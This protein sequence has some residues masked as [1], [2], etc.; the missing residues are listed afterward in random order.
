VSGGGREG[1]RCSL[2]AG[3]GARLRKA[4]EDARIRHIWPTR[5]KRTRLCPSLPGFPSF[6]RATQSHLGLLDRPCPSS[7]HLLHARTHSPSSMMG[8]H[9]GGGYRW[10]GPCQR[11]VLSRPAASTFPPW[12]PW[13]RFVAPQPPG[14]VRKRSM[15]S[16]TARVRALS[17]HDERRATCRR[18]VTQR[19]RA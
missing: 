12:A 2:S 13:R 1:G 6:G 10:S 18:R 17:R 9:R 16:W 5:R 4:Q 15:R 3:E 7:T 11:G 19:S 14:V 8:S